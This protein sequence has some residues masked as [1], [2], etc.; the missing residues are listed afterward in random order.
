MTIVKGHGRYT[1]GKASFQQR[2]PSERDHASP[3]YRRAAVRS[4]GGSAFEARADANGSWGGSTGLPANTSVR[5]YAKPVGART[6]DGLL[7]DGGADVIALGRDMYLNDPISGAVIDIVAG[8]PFGE[9]SLSGLPSRDMYDPYERSM[10]RL[11]TR[12]LLPVVGA[13][14]LTDGA[15]LSSLV[16]DDQAKVFTASIPQDLINARLTP[17]PFFGAPPLVDMTMNSQSMQLLRAASGDPRM[18][19][20]LQHLPKS[21]L[22]PGTHQLQPE[23]TVYVP[24]LSLNHATHGVSLL[25]RIMIVYMLEKALMRGTLEMAY[26]RQRPI[27]HIPVGD[28]NWDPTEEE[29]AQI[30]QLFS[31]A[32]LDP[33]GSVVVTRLGVNV[34]DVGNVSEAWRWQDTADTFSTIKL[35]GLGMPDG[36]LGGDVS[37]DSVSSTMT[38]FLQ[39]MRSFRDYITRQFLYERIFSYIAITNS[40]R[41]E[42]AQEHGRETVARHLARNLSNSASSVRLRSE[43][44]AVAT[45]DDVEMTDY[46]TPRVSWHTSMRPEGDKD[47]LDLLSTLA[48][49]GVP[50]PIRVWAA[51]GGQN[52]EDLIHGAEEDLRLRGELDAYKKAVADLDRASGVGAADQGG[53]DGSDEDAEHSA[54]LLQRAMAPVTPQ[55][56]LNRQ[57][58]PDR[59]TGPNVING[60][61]YVT[62]AR[63]RK[64]VTEKENLV[65]SAAGASVA[66][67]MNRL[68]TTQPVDPDRAMVPGKYGPNL[69]RG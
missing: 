12:T 4:Q 43:W 34:T 15:Y 59:V 69:T 5:S 26:R 57:F 24:R 29:M 47:Y 45:E 25:R 9:C 66:Q 67:R 50:V 2:P 48:E 37:I 33:I 36:L 61:R 55:A 44:M 28:E 41:K 22:Q 64:R 19:R 18:K 14:F 35:K 1:T 62:T 63:E 30:S 11:R 60:H 39:Q 65:V 16:F 20:Y 51:A 8:L 42:D 53:G 7:S 21:F 58:D 31:A 46:V 68:I 32:D 10:D 40:H 17:V 56:L 23:N 38:V 27:M 6:N 52:I 49:K 54:D 13:S 3:G